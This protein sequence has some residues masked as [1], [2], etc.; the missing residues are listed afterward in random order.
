MTLTRMELTGRVEI[1]RDGVTGYICDSDWTEDDALVICRQ[2]GFVYGHP[3]YVQPINV[4]I[5]V[6]KDLFLFGVH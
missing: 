5:N 1:V 4:S 3:T 6:L 2:L